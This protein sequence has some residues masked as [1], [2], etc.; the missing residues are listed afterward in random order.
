MK[1]ER[2]P[3]REVYV[4]VTTSRKNHRKRAT[5]VENK[6]KCCYNWNIPYH[7]SCNRA[8]IF[9]KLRAGRFGLAD[10]VS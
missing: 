5:R 1:T 6:I 4:I 10:F 9:S 7:G 2:K 8:I 3:K